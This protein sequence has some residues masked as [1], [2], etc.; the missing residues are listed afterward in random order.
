MAKGFKT[1]GRQKGSKN[2]STLRRLDI[3][4]DVIHGVRCSA[5]PLDV[6]LR[7]MEHA[8]QAGDL[9]KAHGYAKDAAPYVHPKLASVEHTGDPEN[10]V[11]TQDVSTV[12]RPHRESRDE[13]IARR[14]A[15]LIGGAT[16][17]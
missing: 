16:T 5:T 6:M 8:L 9:D 1:G 14:Q 17:H 11:V 3:A 7:A 4:R 2:K 12:D 15:Q 13:F 10:P